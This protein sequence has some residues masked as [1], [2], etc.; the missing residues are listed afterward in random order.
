MAAKD[1]AHQVRR[2]RACESDDQW[3]TSFFSGASRLRDKCNWEL[4]KVGRVPCVSALVMG[5]VCSSGTLVLINR[6]FDQRGPYE[7]GERSST[8]R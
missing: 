7:T 8:V 1:G 3:S 4:L 5:S 6:L 2:Q